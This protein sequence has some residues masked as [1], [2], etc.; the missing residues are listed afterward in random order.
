[1]VSADLIYDALLRAERRAE[2]RA[3]VTIEQLR[4]STYVPTEST[5][6]LL[7]VAMIREEIGAG[8][9]KECLS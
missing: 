1:M 5:A 6:I 2:D 4:G 3:G 7:A 9:A 8:L